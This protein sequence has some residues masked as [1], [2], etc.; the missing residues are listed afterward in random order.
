MKFS[1]LCTCIQNYCII[2]T[3]KWERG[4]LH[5]NPEKIDD[6]FPLAFTYSSE[7]KEAS[8]RKIQK[9]IADYYPSVNVDTKYVPV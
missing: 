1:F 3:A 2:L 5:S 7:P 6:T 8:F 9:Y 4:D